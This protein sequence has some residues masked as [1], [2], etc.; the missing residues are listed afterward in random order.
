MGGGA[1]A[2]GTACTSSAL[3][4]PC[5]F[6]TSDSCESTHAAD[7]DWAGLGIALDFE[8]SFGLDKF[9]WHSVARQ[10]IGHGQTIIGFKQQLTLVASMRG[11]FKNASQGQSCEWGLFMMHRFLPS[12]HVAVPE[13]VSLDA[14]QVSQHDAN[15][16]FGPSGMSCH[17]SLFDCL[18]CQIV[19]ISHFPCKLELCRLDLFPG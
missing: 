1:G 11:V 10:P 18:H 15:A 4:D 6:I 14:L 13:L 16:G 9:H 12:G 8:L 3:S 17:R 2:G 19:M 5:R 7:A